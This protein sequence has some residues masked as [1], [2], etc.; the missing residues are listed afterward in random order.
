MIDFTQ[1]TYQNIL[2]AMLDRVPD[3]YDKRDTAPIPTALGPAAWALEGFYLSLNQVQQQ[4]FVQTASGDSLDM[5]SV[6]GGLTRYPASAAVRLGV[7]NAAV[8]IGARF[9]TINGESSINFIVT[10]TDTP[11]D[12]AEGFYYY[13]LTAETPGT[14]G[15]EYT[16]PIL[17]ITSIPGLTSAEITDIL[18]PGDDTETDDELRQRLITALNERPFGGNIASYRSYVLGLDGVGAVQVY[19]TWNGGGTVKLSVL[20][21]DFLPASSELVENVQNAVDPPPNQGLGLGMA[22]IG[23]QVTVVAPTELTVNVAATLTLASGYQ[24]GQVQKPIEDAIKAYLLTVRQAW[25]TNTSSTS[26][27]YEANVYLARVTA[28]IVGVEGVV[29]ATNVTLNGGTADLTLTENGTTQQVPTLGTAT[30]T[31]G[32]TT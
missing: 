31:A 19:P 22:P 2:Q 18:I 28:A 25:A 6:I 9:S 26:V 27:V 21:A 10:A 30:L 11:S 4:A 14:I 7:F 5:L 23:A 32:G 16:G 20:G 13:Q 12:P 29:N 8:S 15:N 3:T 17:P 1:E 24:I